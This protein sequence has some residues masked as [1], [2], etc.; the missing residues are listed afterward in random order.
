M[1]VQYRL[2]SCLIGVEGWMILADERTDEP[3]E[4]A[5]LRL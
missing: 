1:P 5:G 4:C 3:H 2:S